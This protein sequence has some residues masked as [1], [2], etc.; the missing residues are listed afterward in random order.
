MWRKVAAD[1]PRKA[2]WC[3][4]WKE[5]PGMANDILIVDDEADI[6]MLI[7]GILQ[8]EGYDTCDAGNSDSALDLLRQRRPSPVVL[9]IWLETS[10]LDGMEMLSVIKQEWPSM[11]VVMVSGNGKMEDAANAIHLGDDDFND[12]P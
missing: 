9:D 7:T 5:L 8:D 3:R 10:A 6:R 4:L 1:R 11:P 2:S 12:K